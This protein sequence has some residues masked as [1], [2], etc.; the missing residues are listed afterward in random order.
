MSTNLGNEKSIKNR[1]S[2][3][4]S[5]DM[6]SL[7]DSETVAS[8]VEVVLKVEPTIRIPISAG[9][10]AISF[11]PL[12]VLQDKAVLLSGVTMDKAFEI[13]NTDVGLRIGEYQMSSII[14]QFHRNILKDKEYPLFKKPFLRNSQQSLSRN[15]TEFMLQRT[16]FNNYY[17]TRFGY[18][19]LIE[20]HMNINV[21]PS[22][23]ELWLDYMSDAMDGNDALLDE[24]RE[25]LM[26]YFRFTAYYLV[27]AQ[28]K[29]N[30]DILL[31]TDDFYD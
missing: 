4:D 28:Q 24:E 25:M 29:Q 27:A 3:I 10:T 21:S 26:N 17:T 23:A 22:N 1:Q 20:K 2:S 12:Q 5:Y 9:E 11:H 15:L 7:H 19:K 16:G 18:F 31:M 8:Q 6:N 30:E 13:D 14:N